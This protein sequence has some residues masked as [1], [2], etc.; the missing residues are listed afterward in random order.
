MKVSG[1]KYWIGRSWS[2]GYFSSGIESIK[3]CGRSFL[4]VNKNDNAS[5]TQQMPVLTDGNNTNNCDLP[6]TPVI[7]TPE[8]PASP[9][10][11]FYS[12]FFKDQPLLN[13]QIELENFQNNLEKEVDKFRKYLSANNF[14]IFSEIKS[15]KDFWLK[16]TTEYPNLAKLA[17]ILLNICSS[18]AYIER[19]FSIC[20][21]VQKKRSCNITI[22]LFKK[23]CMLR[24][25]LNI[26]KELNKL[27]L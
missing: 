15:T 8:G 26:L 18:S 5:N 4:F 12:Q 1:L 10:N 22:D 27:S 11:T 21:F 25:N 24:S 6:G 20:G 7:N 9:S 3:E 13:D 23:R 19:F 14:R 16:H 17:L 2:S